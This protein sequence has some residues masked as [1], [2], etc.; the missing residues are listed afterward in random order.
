MIHLYLIGQG[1]DETK[2]RNMVANF[3]IQDNVT[4][5]G[6]QPYENV[7]RY[8]SQADMFIMPS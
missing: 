7:Y 3:N 1:P 5:L 2:L 4:F 8:M 6:L